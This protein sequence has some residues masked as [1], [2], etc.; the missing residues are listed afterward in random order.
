MSCNIQQ[1]FFK[2]FSYHQSIC[3]SYSEVLPCVFHFYTKVFV[4]WTFI[5]QGIT[6]FHSAVL[7]AIYASFLTQCHCCWQDADMFW[8]F[9]TLRPETTHQVS[10]LFSDRGIPNGYR[11]M[12]GYGSHTFKLVNSEGK[13]VYCKFHYKT[14]QGIK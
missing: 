7:N 3:F 6:V 10:F 8:D 4:Y 2:H 11:H 9:I 1:L 14:D 13:A 12:N 5:P